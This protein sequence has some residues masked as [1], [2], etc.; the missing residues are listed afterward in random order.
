M[1]D[2]DRYGVDLLTPLRGQP[3]GPV[4]VDV[5]RAVAKGE[6]R[7]ATRRA[8][9]AGAA[10]L[11]LLGGVWVATRPDR[12]RPRPAPEVTGP[13][14]PRA[15]TLESLEVPPDFPGDAQVM[16]ADPT[17]RY[18]IGMVGIHEAQ[19][20][21]LWDGGRVVKLGPGTGE[22][23]DVN[24][25]GTVVGRRLRFGD[26]TEH[27]W[28][29]RD[30]TVRQLA[31]VEA[32]ATGINDRGQIVGV[33]GGRPVTWA[34]PDAEPVALPIPA[35]YELAHLA[36]VGGID[37]DGTV[38]GTLVNRDDHEV[39]VAWSPGGPARELAAPAGRPM[40][41]ADAIRNGWVI[42]RS[43]N[44]LVRWNLRAAGPPIV[45]PDVW[46]FDTHGPNASG[47]LVF[48]GNNRAALYAGGTEIRLP[49]PEPP[50]FS[51]P[52]PG[53]TPD[54]EENPARPMSISDDG[55]TII[56]TWAVK[57]VGDR[58][59]VYVWTCR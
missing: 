21:V 44:S 54:P 10:V 5:R 17:G 1:D 52:I 59:N 32:F 27:A 25:A 53:R 31:G 6:R 58:S 23:T 3:R 12:D 48:G 20:A 14:V 34:S 51:S 37:E 18:A 22:P 28:V 46:G 56:G 24:S 40:Y 29:Y 15:C 49:L 41:G 16:G 42:G 39:A 7:R 8:V 57:G 50:P 2:D 30:G 36:E 11:V 4:G 9:A 33:S 55:H 43:G 38:V 26:G 47:W 35:G 19:I 13:P 45:M